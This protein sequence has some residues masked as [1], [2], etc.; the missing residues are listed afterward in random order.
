M[1]WAEVELRCIWELSQFHTELRSWGG[2]SQLSKTRSV[3]S[4]LQPCMDGLVIGRGPPWGGR[5]SSLP[6]SRKPPA[7]TPCALSQRHSLA[8]GGM[9]P[10]SEQDSGRVPRHPPPPLQAAHVPLLRSP[11]VPGFFLLLRLQAWVMIISQL[12]SF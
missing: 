11:R 10:Q 7:R 9:A 2:P 1:N 12:S 5:A 4:P 3:A 8:A 6:G